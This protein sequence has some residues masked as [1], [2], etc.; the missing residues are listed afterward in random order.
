MAT[1]VLTLLQHMGE[2]R[3]AELLWEVDKLVMQRFLDLV[4]G[5]A[6]KP[7]EHCL[8]V[9]DNQAE[10]LAMAAQYELLLC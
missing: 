3:L 10:P 6:K 7:L 4:E 9:V 1:L 2:L 5:T 8:A